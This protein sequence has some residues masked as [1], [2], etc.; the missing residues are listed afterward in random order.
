MMLVKGNFRLK[1][2]VPGI[3]ERAA[4]I[5]LLSDPFLA[6]PDEIADINNL[7]LWLK[8]EWQ[9]HAGWYNRQPDF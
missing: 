6:T 4:T 3:K 7:R 2:A 9:D 8:G 1:E 5:L